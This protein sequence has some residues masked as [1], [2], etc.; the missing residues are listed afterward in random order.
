MPTWKSEYLEGRQRS[1]KGT[2]GGLA[3]QI[4]AAGDRETAADTNALSGEGFKSNF[5]VDVTFQYCCRW[6]PGPPPTPTPC[7]VQPPACRVTGRLPAAGGLEVGALRMNLMGSSW[8]WLHDVSVRMTPLHRDGKVHDV[9]L[10][11]DDKMTCLQVFQPGKTVSTVVFASAVISA[12][13]GCPHRVPT[14]QAAHRRALP[15]LPSSRPSSSMGRGW[16]QAICLISPLGTVHLTSWPCLCGHI[17]ICVWNARCKM[18][19]SKQAPTP[20]IP[21]TLDTVCRSVSV[22]RRRSRMGPCCCK[23]TGCCTPSAATHPVRS[24]TLPTSPA[25]PKQMLVKPWEDMQQPPL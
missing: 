16:V 15:P 11:L 6:G 2:A 4:A 20:F 9:L 12:K 17:G 19:L 1:H 18:W 14:L 7:Q 5:T 25:S 23:W 8:L 3:I 10:S 21:N 13:A 22:L 24:R